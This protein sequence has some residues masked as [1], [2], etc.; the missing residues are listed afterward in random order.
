[1]TRSVF[2]FFMIWLLASCNQK[3]GTDDL[4]IFT[5]NAVKDYIP[6]VEPLPPLRPT[7]VFIYT[8]SDE[9]DPFNPGNLGIQEAENIDKVNGGEGPD[10][11]RRKEPL[12]VFPIDALQLVGVI[13]QG[14]INWAIVSAPDDTVHRVTQGNYMGQNHGEIMLVDT[15]QVQVIEFIRNPAGKWEKKDAN[16]NLLE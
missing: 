13:T 1:M 5:E 4:E 2:K 14:G 8:A 9:V 7:A 15:S 10:L 3:S 11:S 6:E 16:L 12:E